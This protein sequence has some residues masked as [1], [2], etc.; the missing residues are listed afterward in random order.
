[1]EWV[2]K[3]FQES[4]GGRMAECLSAAAWVGETQLCL[5][6]LSKQLHEN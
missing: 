2:K 1:M 3:Q 5:P 4:G 6:D